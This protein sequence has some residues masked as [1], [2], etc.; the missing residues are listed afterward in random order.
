MVMTIA[1]HLLMVTWLY[2]ALLAHSLALI[3]QTIGRMILCG[4]RNFLDSY[5]LCLTFFGIGGVIGE[6]LL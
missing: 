3:F 1:K 6:T 4:I 2:S 5:I